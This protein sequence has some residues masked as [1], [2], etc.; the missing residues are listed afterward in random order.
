MK[1]FLLPVILDR[2]LMHSAV[3]QNANSSTASSGFSFDVYGNSRSMKYF[4]LGINS[5]ARK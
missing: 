3:V 4:P 2:V 5:A 1:R